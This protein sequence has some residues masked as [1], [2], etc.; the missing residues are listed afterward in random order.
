M[1]NYFIYL[2]ACFITFPVIVSFVA[3]VLFDQIYVHKWKVIHSTV[4]WTTI[5]YMV[6]VPMILKLLF[7][8]SFIGILLLL[9]LVILMM[10]IYYQWKVHTE[11]AIKRAVK[12]LWRICFILFFFLYF[13]LVCIGIAGRIFY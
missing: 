2:I 7:G 9:L 4:A 1:L 11:V 3:Y 8:E 6:A 5:W 12:M 10:I 13:L